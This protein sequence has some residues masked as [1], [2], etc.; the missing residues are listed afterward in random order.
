MTT[1]FTTAPII[2]VIL[3]GGSGMR[4]WPA[5][6]ENHPKQFLSLTNDFSLL[7]NTARRALRAC[8][9]DARAIVCVTHESMR[10]AVSEHLAEI[11]ND[12]P[13]HILSEPAARNTAA[14][15]AFAARYVSTTFGPDAILWILPADHHIEHEDILQAALQ[16]ALTAVHDSRLVTFGITPTRADTGYGYIRL[17]KGL[18]AHEGVHAVCHFREKPDTATAQSYLD[19]GEYL[20]NSGMFLFNAATVLKEFE[21]HAPGIL[22]I[23]DAAMEKSITDPC[24]YTYTAVVAQPFDKAVIEK[25][26]AVA[27]VPCDPGWSDI[28][29]WESLWDLR[30][31]DHNNNVIEGRAAAYNSSGC[32]IQAKDRLIAV[33]GLDDIIVIETED[34]ILIGNKNDSDSMKEL[35]AGLKKLDAPETKHIVRPSEP[36]QP[37]TMVRKIGQTES[38]FIGK[39]PANDKRHIA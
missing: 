11:D 27:V 21:T 39:I 14:A 2:P 15:I 3:C 7:Q 37:W 23:V 12:A 30:A 16:K 22:E 28:G 4:L 25:S 18:E 38:V 24:P 36:A 8:G 13:L 5:S 20:W 32:L 35:V 9:A 19:S 1:T 29:S 31:K 10:G 6:R 17:G 26:D 33:A 34:A